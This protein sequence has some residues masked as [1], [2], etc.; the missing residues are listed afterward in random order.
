MVQY[1][2]ERRQS[3]RSTAALS[4][5]MSVLVACSAGCS[6]TGTTKPYESSSST[7]N[8]D[9]VQYAYI[10]QV[11]VG[12]TVT[13]DQIDYFGEG[14][15]EAQCRKDGKDPATIDAAPCH[16]Y[17][18]RDRHSTLT[19]P[20]SSQVSISLIDPKNLEPVPANEVGL[21]QQVERSSRERPQ[22]Y[23]L[24][25]NAGQVVQIDEIYTP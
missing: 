13:L 22:P 15:A 24:T 8:T 21:E 1:A 18:V 6:A 10:K 2:R 19:L 12:R 17:Y 11:T 3:R 5:I 16:D 25:V 4:P 14:Q 23:K 7:I 9:G 20:L